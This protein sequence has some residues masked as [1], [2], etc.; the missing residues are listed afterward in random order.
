MVAQADIVADEN[1][2]RRERL[3]PGFIMSGCSC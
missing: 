3:C 1:D 2:K